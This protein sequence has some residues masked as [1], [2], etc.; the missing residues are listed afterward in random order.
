ME[1]QLAIAVVDRLGSPV[2]GVT[3]TVA[4]ENGETVQLVTDASGQAMYASAQDARVSVAESTLPQG[5]SEALSVTAD[6]AAMEGPVQMKMATRTSVV[7]EHAASGTVQVEAVLSQIDTHARR[8]DVPLAGVNVQ[9]LCDTPVQLVTDGDG[10]ASVTLEEGTYD[11]ALTYEGEEDAVLPAAQGQVIVI[12]GETTAV[13]L[14]ATRRRGRVAVQADAQGEKLSGG[15]VTLVS[16]ETGETFGPYAMDAEGLAVS[17]LLEAGA[18]RVSVE[19]PQNMEVMAIRGGDGAEA[20][21]AEGL[22]LEVLR[23]NFRRPMCRC[24]AVRRR[25][26]N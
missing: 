22:T 24:S 20:D 25:H 9:I 3:L 23:A 2:P 16:E 13:E 6:G 14:T 1:A 26:L 12:G 10:R 5:V 7:F 17:D 19:A 21:T 8:V 4:Q 11:I 15:S 18:Y